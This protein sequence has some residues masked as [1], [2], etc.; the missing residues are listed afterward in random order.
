[1]IA[2]PERPLQAIALVAAAT[3]C[4]A[5]LDTTTKFIGATLSL[6]LVMWVRFTLQTL[7]TLV[8]M[9][10][11]RG[12][13]LLQTN[14]PR[15][16]LVRGLSLLASSSLAFFSLRLLPVAEFTAIV[17]LTPLFMTLVAAFALHERVSRLRWVLVCGG[18]VGALIVIRPGHDA[19]TWASLLPLAL[20]VM[21]GGFQLLTSE[22]AKYDSAV[23]IHFYT[24]CVGALLSTL[25]LP[26]VWQGLPAWPVSGLL[27]LV[28]L[29]SNMGHLLLIMGYSRAPVATL[30]PYLYLQIPF[31][32]LGGYLVFARTPDAWSVLGIGVIALCGIAGTWVAARERHADIRVEHDA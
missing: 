16:Q 15:L 5:T 26:F 14:R 30:T 13:A 29:A 23:T 12:R 7:S 1:M 9:W 19:F 3:V 32:M 8:V 17:M 31:A 24:G 6:V 11:S 10:P 4:F 25:A 22:L 2:R 18:F 28:A 20:V 21:S 27:L